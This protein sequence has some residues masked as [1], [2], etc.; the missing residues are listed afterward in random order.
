MREKPIAVIENDA[1][2]PNYQKH[3]E[4]GPYGSYRTQKN[5][6]G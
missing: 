1:T 3:K 5:G 4:G 6:R 2:V